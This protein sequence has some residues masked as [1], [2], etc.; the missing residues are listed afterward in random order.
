MV[1][2]AGRSRLGG[3][4]WSHNG[5][6]VAQAAQNSM[7]VEAVRVAVWVRSERGKQK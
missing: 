5:G 1:T 3:G 2:R 7:K 6:R 4:H